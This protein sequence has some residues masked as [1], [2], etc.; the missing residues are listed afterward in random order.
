M[1]L[2]YNIYKFGDLFGVEVGNINILV[3]VEK[4][5]VEAAFSSVHYQLPVAISDGY[6]VQKWR[7]EADS[8]QRKMQPLQSAFRHARGY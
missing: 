3:R 1:L 6:A 5:I 4:Q 8:E 2:I 7:L